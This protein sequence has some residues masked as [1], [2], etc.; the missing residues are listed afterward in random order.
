MKFSAFENKFQLEICGSYR[1]GTAYS[2][3]IDV[4]FTSDLDDYGFL[5]RFIQKLEEGG[6]LI[7]HLTS[8]KK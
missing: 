3:D 4:L 6:F 5:E 2:N 1:R 7:E 8:V